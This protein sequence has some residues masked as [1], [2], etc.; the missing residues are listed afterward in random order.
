MQHSYIGKLNKNLRFQVL[1]GPPKCLE[2]KNQWKEF[3]RI[4]VGIVSRCGMVPG[5]VDIN[6]S[7]FCSL[8]SWEARDLKLCLLCL[9]HLPPKLGQHWFSVSQM[10]E[11]AQGPS[12]RAKGEA[13]ECFSYHFLFTLML[14]SR[15]TAT[16]VRDSCL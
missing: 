12:F 11:L 3:P 15:D 10:S 14:L 1:L 9:W 2:I 8:E 13:R 5:W 16:D 7:R 6:S 4:C